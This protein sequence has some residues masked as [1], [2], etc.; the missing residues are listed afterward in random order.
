MSAI[1]CTCGLDPYKAPELH[2]PTCP[3]KLHNVGI[4]LDAAA[5]DVRNHAHAAMAAARRAES[6]ADS[7]LVM[8]LASCVA[9]YLAYKAAREIVKAV[10]GET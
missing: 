1:D 2:A 7:A 3:V 10:K 9:A 4:A 5:D 6:A 8:L